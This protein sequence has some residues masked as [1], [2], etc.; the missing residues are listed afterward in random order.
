MLFHPHTPLPRKRRTDQIERAARELLNATRTAIAERN[1]STEERVRI[2]TS[3]LLI[4]VNEGG[5]VND[6]LCRAKQQVVSASAY[7]IAAHDGIAKLE[8]AVAALVA[9]CTGRVAA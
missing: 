9:L 5:T 8:A 1:N 7:V 6:E 4:A 2:A 3:R